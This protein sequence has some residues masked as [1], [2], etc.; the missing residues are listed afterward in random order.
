M[1]NIYVSCGYTFYFRFFRMSP[2]RFDHL[3]G[4]VAPR[5]RKNDT[6]FRKAPQ[7]E[8]LPIILRFLASGEL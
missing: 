8:C 5:M 6:N 7:A 1:L 3:L 4:L 2:Q